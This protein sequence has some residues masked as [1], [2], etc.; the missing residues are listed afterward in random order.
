MSK[1]LWGGE[2]ESLN[3]VGLK[4]MEN[5]AHTEDLVE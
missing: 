3:K 1:F 4:N 2:S 5:S